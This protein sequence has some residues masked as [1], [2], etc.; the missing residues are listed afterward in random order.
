MGLRPIPD[1]ALATSRPSPA[2]VHARHN[3]SPRLRK[4]LVLEL[5]VGVGSLELVDAFPGSVLLS[6]PEP[7][8]QYAP[9]TSALLRFQRPIR[10]WQDAAVLRRGEDTGLRWGIAAMLLQQADVEDIMQARSVRQL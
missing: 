5:E 9:D 8:D 10:G 3:I 2:V 4:Q 7:L 1:A 6:Q